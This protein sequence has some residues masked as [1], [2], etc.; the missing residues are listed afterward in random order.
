[1]SVCNDAI[2]LLREISGNNKN[3]FE[4]AYKLEKI[5]K[6]TATQ[7]AAAQQENERLQEIIFDIGASA[8]ICETCCNAH[9]DYDGIMDCLIDEYCYQWSKKGRSYW[10][11]DAREVPD[12][13]IVLMVGQGR[14]NF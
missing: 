13:L 14:R 6:D 8:M 7:L 3:T 5:I 9:Y 4:A 10:N 11:C 2:K 12:A 1:M